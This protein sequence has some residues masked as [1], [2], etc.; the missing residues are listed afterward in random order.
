MDVISWWCDRCYYHSSVFNCALRLQF[1]YYLF[2]V[3]LVVLLFYVVHVIF[4]MSYFIFFLF[5]YCYYY[6]IFFKLGGGGGGR[7]PYLVFSFLP[8]SHLSLDPSQDT[9]Q[10]YGS[11]CTTDVQLV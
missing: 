4:H 1:L 8:S 11:K 7:F 5:C 3:F 6:F 9:A 2:L 10:P